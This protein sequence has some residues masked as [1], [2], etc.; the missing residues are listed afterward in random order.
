[1]KKLLFLAA[2]M[3]SALNLYS[4]QMIN[5]I[6]A[7]VEN[8]PIT[9]YEVYSL[10]EQLRASE[11]DALNL[12]IRDRLED[13]QIKNLNISV[14]PFELNDRIES[15]A[16]Q[17]GMTNSQFRSSI[18]AQGMD[19][20]EFKNNIE[21]KM[22]QEKLYKSILAEA[23]KNVNEQKAKM[24]FDANPDKFKVFS[25]AK[26]VLYRAKNPEELE[27]QKTSPSLLNSVQTQELSLDYQSIDPRLAAIIAGTN[28]GEFTQILQGADSFDMFY[29]KEKIGS[30]TP[31]FADVKDNV[32]NELYQGEQEKLMADYFDKLR[33]K[34]KIQI[35][36]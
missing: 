9:L 8:E 31:S 18:Q 21:K 10:K 23:G 3:L 29:V 28:N 4:A 19:F 6:A 15:I 35:L 22:L 7:I 30:Y 16:K 34:A 33:A 5:G 27:A 12:L 1:M 2:G 14:T 25:A 26:V 11:Q 17:N 24:Y 36:R 13:A 32:I 20:L